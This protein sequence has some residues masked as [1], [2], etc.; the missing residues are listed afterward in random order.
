[1]RQTPTV[2]SQDQNIKASAVEFRPD[3]LGGG[4]WYVTWISEGRPWEVSV[5]RLPKAQSG[6][7]GWH[8]GRLFGYGAQWCAAY[9]RKPTKATRHPV[10]TS[11]VADWGGAVAS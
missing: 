8:H 7:R 11:G 4:D 10:S 3:R 9:S 6:G 5:M 2:R 1:M